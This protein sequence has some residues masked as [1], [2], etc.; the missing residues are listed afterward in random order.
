MK[1]GMK[2][3]W[4]VLVLIIGVTA[5][6]LPACA[7]DDSSI[8]NRVLEIMD[9]PSGVVSVLGADDAALALEIARSGNYLVHVVD[10][11]RT[12]VRS[13]Q[14]ILD[15]DGLYGKKT[16]AEKGD[17]SS[18]HYADN[19]IDLILSTSLNSSSLEELS[20]QEMLRVLC[21]KGKAVLV[22]RKDE[23]GKLPRT[24]QI[25]RWLKEAGIKDAS[26]KRERSG[27]WVCLTKPPLEGVDEWTHWEHLPDNN[28]VSTDEVIKSPYMTQ[29]L[30]NPLYIAMPAIT[31]AA[32]GRI[33]IAM[34]H[35]AHHVREEPW[36]NTLIARN[37]YN[38]SILWTRKLP[39]GYLAH[40]SAFVATEDIF[41]MI[42]DDGQRCLLLDAKTG[43]E[44][45]RISVPGVRGEWK[46][47]A[48]VD[49]V[50]YGLAGPKKDPAESTVVRSENTHWSWQELSRGY[51]QKRVPWGFGKTVFAYDIKRRKVLWTHE[52]EQSTDSRALAMGAGKIFLYGPDSHLRCLNAKNGK[53]EWTNDDPETRSLIEQPGKG[54]GS[55]PGFR[56]MCFCLYT[57][58]V[59]FYEAQTRMNIVAVSTKDGSRLWSHRK[60]TNNPNMIYVDGQLLVGIGPDG[61]TMVVDP[62]SGEIKEDLGF[63]KRSCARLTATPDSLFCRG[64]NEGVTRYDRLT[65]KISFNGAFRP[66]CNDGIIGANGLLYLGPWACDCNLSIMGRV[67]LC[68]AGD[69]VFVRDVKIDE[70]LERGDGNISRVTP[71]DLSPNDWPTYRG[72]NDRSA[73][74]SVRVSESASRIWQFAPDYPFRPTAPVSAGSLVFIA[75]D[76]GKVRAIDA[77]TGLLKWI[78]RTAGPIQQP[79][80]VWNGRLYV[81][82]GDGFVYALEA[83]TGRMLWRFRAA[84]V[85]R[86]MMVY[87]SLCSTWPVH[88]GVLVKDG[89]AYAAAGIIDYD[90]TYVYALDAKTGKLIWCNDSSGHLDK[91]I[92]KG[93]SAQGVLTIANGLLWMPGGN[94]VSPAAYDLK[95]G[96]YSAAPVNNGTPRANRGEE[97]GRFAENYIITGGR[98]RYSAGENV[99]NPGQ[100]AAYRAEKGV[101]VNDNRKL[102][103][104]KIPPAWNNE[105]FICVSGRNTVLESFTTDVVT[106]HLETQRSKKLPEPE[107]RAN[108]LRGKDVVALAAAP[109]AVLAAYKEPQPR[110]LYPNWFVGALS[111]EDGSPLWRYKLPSSALVGGCAV[112]RKGRGS[113]A[114]E[115][116]GLVCLG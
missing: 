96:E 110:S 20:L 32:G 90:G 12:K 39:D 37:G 107:W 70:R 19:T 34:G 57:P 67:A 48:M 63:K 111:A 59:L 26:V 101:G 80:T 102:N 71:F 74:T 24:S 92:R 112:D 108:T 10:P 13:A 68:S 114:M 3:Y 53:I 17:F 5:A 6:C 31:T 42:G 16:V 58:D 15:T 89:V 41:Y 86:R 22:F 4:L 18:L 45:D 29:W 51:Y 106:N 99:V 81:G 113:A 103:S 30:G 83:A 1:T 91:E 64:W 54:L 84:P 43:N 56:T 104:G 44:L 23:S 28:P 100:F 8:V 55:T 79:P 62:L 66:S 82:S 69:F 72:G 50:L 105:R 49:G 47:M 33:F 52:E 14:T 75:G 94:V 46:W 9:T 77:A 78:Y 2:A 85:E 65:K 7:A 27:L 35:I 98:L 36:L 115:N 95:T 88:S 76:D 21:P 40:R 116:G 38:G 25:K 61:N 73:G 93:V 97:I 11:D 87:D 60:T 109:N